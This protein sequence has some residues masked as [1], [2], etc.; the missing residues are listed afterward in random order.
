[1]TGIVWAWKIKQEQTPKSHQKSKSMGYCRPYRRPLL[2][3]PL[4]C[5]LLLVPDIATSFTAS[6]C[7]KI[8][9]ATGLTNQF[10]NWKGHGIRYQHNE[11]KEGPPVL[12]IHGLFV[13]S[14]HWR[15]TLSWLSEH[16][17][18]AYALDLLGCGWSDKPTAQAAQ[19]VN[20][21][22]QRFGNNEPAVVSN[23]ALGSACGTQ[24]RVRD[25]DLRHPLESPYNFF[26][27]ADLIAD[28]CQD[29]ILPNNK[30]QYT[31]VSI[32]CNSIGTI[33]SLQATIDH[34]HWFNGV[35]VV[36][37]NFRELHSA[38]VPFS[39]LSMPL[40]KQ[41]QSL[42]RNKGQGVFDL[43]ANP[44]TVK[45]ILMEPYANTTAIDDTLVKV[46]LDPL[47]TDGASNVVFDTLSYSAG[48]LPEQ[49]LQH[50][51]L[52]KPVWVLYGD[53]DPWTPGPRVEALKQYDPVQHVYKLSGVGH[54]PH[55]EA[56]GLVHPLLEE[57]LKAIEKKK[58]VE[59]E[60]MST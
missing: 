23:V 13:N 5:L 25:V 11:N 56:P 26:T 35:F 16:D 34:P 46:L 28:F 1:M 38:E 33:S 12:L 48:P 58:G 53:E 45:N 27:W 9:P 4:L 2:P 21:E 50:F 60:A 15:Q 49:Q 39:K 57:F 30:D 55:D 10:Y 36:C 32:V 44:S 40:I 47:L 6:R 52:H 51:P 29:I 37:P 14:D 7:P 19:S 43:M 42:L 31:D 8:S 18:D 22:T 24:T 17:Y 20:G 59:T 3:L 54:C 41:V